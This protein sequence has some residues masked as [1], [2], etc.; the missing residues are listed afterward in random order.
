MSIDIETPE[1]IR[2]VSMH[3]V[4]LGAADIVGIDDYQSAHIKQSMDEDRGSYY[5]HIKFT[6]D[7]KDKKQASLRYERYG[8]NITLHSENANDGRIYYQ[9]PKAKQIFIQ[10]MGKTQEATTLAL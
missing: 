10:A 5:L 8:D 2:G 1:E 3:E 9:G 4:E 7:R 6:I